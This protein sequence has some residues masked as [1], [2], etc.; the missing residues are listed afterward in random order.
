WHR[1]SDRIGRKPSFVLIS[2][3][4]AI[5]FCGFALSQ[6]YNGIFIFRGLSGIGAIYGPLG[7]TI[8]ADVTPMRQRGKALAYL[9]GSAMAGGIVAPLL[10]MFLLKQGMEWKGLMFLAAAF[11]LGSSAISFFFLKESAPVR[12]ARNETAELNIDMTSAPKESGLAKTIAVMGRNKN[13]MV[14]MVGYTVTLGVHCLFKDLA[15]NIVRTRCEPN[16]DSDG[17]SLYSYT[18]LAGTVGGAIASLVCGPMIKRIG[19]KGVIYIGQACAVVALA[20]CAFDSDKIYPYWYYTLAT[21]INRAGD[22]FAHPA[23]IHLCSE[24]ASPQDRGMMLGLF[25]IGNSLGRS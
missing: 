25:Q 7:N 22:G 12:I 21:F 11:S 1:I 18:V 13:L 10:N 5:C 16:T 9:N 23:F 3:N 4:Y 2:I 15:G 19:E 14:V 8:V 17:V 20:M 6:G 24:W